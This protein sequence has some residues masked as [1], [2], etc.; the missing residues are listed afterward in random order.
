MIKERFG[1]FFITIYVYPFI[2]MLYTVSNILKQDRHTSNKI[3]EI[4]DDQFTTRGSILCA[5][6][7]ISPPYNLPIK[8]QLKIK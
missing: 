4:N 2:K 3:K 6:F 8:Y 1:I 7:K 5:N